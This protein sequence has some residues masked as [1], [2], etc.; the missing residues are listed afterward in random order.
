MLGEVWQGFTAKKMVS[1]NLWKD[2][3]LCAFAKAM[4]FSLVSFDKRIPDEDVL[5]L[6]KS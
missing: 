3:Y 5:V 1:P 2:A 6:E 4:G